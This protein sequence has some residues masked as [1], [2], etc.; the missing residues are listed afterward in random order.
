MRS[1]D[2]IKEANSQAIGYRKNIH[3]GT[4]VW[5]II[6]TD[7]EIETVS[8]GWLEQRPRKVDFVNWNPALQCPPGFFCTPQV[9]GRPAPKVGEVSNQPLPLPR[10]QDKTTSSIPLP[11]PSSTSPT[12]QTTITRSAPVSTTSS[13]PYAG[14]SG[15]QAIQKLNPSIKDVNRIYVGQELTMPDGSKYKVAAG[16][17]LDKIAVKQ[18]QRPAAPATPNPQIDFADL[19]K[20]YEQVLSEAPPPNVVRR[21]TLPSPKPTPPQVPAV[22]PSPSAASYVNPASSK[23]SNELFFN[24]RLYRKMGTIWYE[25]DLNTGARKP[26]PGM[27]AA[28]DKLAAGPKQ[29]AAQS[30]QTKP[31][32]TV[33]SGPQIPQG[34]I[35]TPSN[36][37]GISAGERPGRKGPV[38]ISAS[39]AT[40]LA[41]K[42]SPIISACTRF[43]RFVAGSTVG[44]IAVILAAY[45]FIEYAVPLI[46]DLYKDYKLKTDPEYYN[47][48]VDEL[49]NSIKPYLNK[50]KFGGLTPEQQKD[51]TVAI[52]KWA[53]VTGNTVPSHIKKPPITK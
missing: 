14:S 11:R 18:S 47:K 1:R 33:G 6:R 2:F 12:Q 8:R 17:T 9:D 22:A 29:S 21:G 50:D 44:G 31:T 45:A 7:G 32:T 51:I 25:I 39:R 38:G 41:V 24:D 30:S 15:A 46:E 27:Q 42:S 43:L 36:N 10:Q 13:K 3:N 19:N 28:L 49:Y 53:E 26:V 16:D 52:I 37:I 5:E 48:S 40:D 20:S 35:K 34:D 4:D 23:I